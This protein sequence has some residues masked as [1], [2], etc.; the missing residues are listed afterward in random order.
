MTDVRQV[1][2]I[3]SKPWPAHEFRSVDV[4]LLM[5]ASLTDL[6]LRPGTG[7]ASSGTVDRPATLVNNTNNVWESASRA[8]AS[9]PHLRNL[10]V[11][12]DSKDLRPWHTAAVETRLFASL[13]NVRR[14]GQFVLCLPNLPADETKRGLSGLSSSYLEGAELENK[15]FT[16]ERGDRPDGWD[17][18]LSTRFRLQRA[19][20]QAVAA[21]FPHAEL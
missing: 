13:S 8:L 4:S 21:H 9:L 18:Y 12:I 10:R 2:R 11:W 19:G 6:Y 20:L 7:R 14:P 16:V 5:T 15:P 3:L 1:N 17:V